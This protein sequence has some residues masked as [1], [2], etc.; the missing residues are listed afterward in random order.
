MTSL[1]VGG[2]STAPSDA[3]AP[4]APVRRLHPYEFELILLAALDED[5]IA[6]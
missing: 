5:E 1:A 2:D 4:A 3:P 6:C